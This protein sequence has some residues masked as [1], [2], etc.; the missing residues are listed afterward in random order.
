[1]P[2]KALAA[3][4]GARIVCGLTLPIRLLATVSTGSVMASYA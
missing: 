4:R 3:P 1:M 2:G